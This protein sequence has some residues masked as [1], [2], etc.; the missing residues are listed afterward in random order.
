MDKHTVPTD[1]QHDMI[2]RTDFMEKLHLKIIGNGPHVEWDD[3]IIV[4]KH[5]GT[6]S[7]TQS[8]KVIL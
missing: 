7:D 5:R 6:I 1:A 8:T 2:I 3:V 4:M